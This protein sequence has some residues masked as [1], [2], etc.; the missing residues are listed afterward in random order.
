MPHDVFYQLHKLGTCKMLYTH[1]ISLRTTDIRTIINRWFR[2]LSEPE[3]RVHGFV[4]S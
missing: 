4:D 3:T 1:V 2:N